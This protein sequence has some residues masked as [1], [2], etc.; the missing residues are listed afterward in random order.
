MVSGFSLKT[1]NFLAFATKFDLI[2]VFKFDISE[3]FDCTVLARTVK[4]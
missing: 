4:L 2:H 3:N 1:L